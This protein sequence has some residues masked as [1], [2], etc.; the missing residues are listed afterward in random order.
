MSSDIIDFLEKCKRH[1][2]FVESLVCPEC[3]NILIKDTLTAFYT[4][5]LQYRCRCTSC[6]FEGKCH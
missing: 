5:P 3:G 1:G 6:D 4:S 2:S